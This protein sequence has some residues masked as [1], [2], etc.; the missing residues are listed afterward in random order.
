MSKITNQKVHRL[1]ISIFASQYNH[2]RKL[3]DENCTT[4]S[5]ILRA[6][7]DLLVEKQKQTPSQN[8]NQNK[9][10]FPNLPLNLDFNL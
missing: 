6:H 8:K 1:H 4:I 3:A 2:L 7:I 9:D 5:E 10:Y